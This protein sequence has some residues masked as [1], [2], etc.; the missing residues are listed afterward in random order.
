M[1]SARRDSNGAAV[2]GAGYVDQPLLLNGYKFDLRL[3]VCVTSCAPPRSSIE[4]CRLCTEKYEAPSATTT[5]TMTTGGGGPST[6]RLGPV[7]A[8]PRHASARRP[9]A[10]VAQRRRAAA[11]SAARR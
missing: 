11:R 8:H 6:L 9:P 2:R 4:A 7:R 3:Y 1:S 5:Q 10:L